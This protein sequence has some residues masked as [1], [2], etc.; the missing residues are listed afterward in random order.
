M[1]YDREKDPFADRARSMAAPASAAR[2]LT[3][4]DTQELDFYPKALRVYLPL[5]LG[6]ATIRVTPLLA[7]DD[8]AVTLTFL[9]GVF[10]EPLAIRRLWSTG[11]TP[12]V[13]VHGYEV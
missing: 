12:G 2:L 11:T 10:T 5:S 4:S 7:A 13:V 8:A 1:S 6:E 9:T 3:P